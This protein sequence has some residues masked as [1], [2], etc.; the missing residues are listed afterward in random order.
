MQSQKNNMDDLFESLLQEAAVR[1]FDEYNQ[2]LTAPD[3]E[4]EFS[5]E[6]TKKMKK[7]FR[8]HKRQENMKKL[9][10]VAA[11]AACV[12]VAVTVASSVAVFS[13]DAWRVRVMNFVFDPKKIAT[14][15]NFNDNGGTT[16][17]DEY[18]RLG[19]VPMGFELTD[20]IE[21]SKCNVLYFERGEEYFFFDMQ[22]IKV[23]MTIDTENAVLENVTVKGHEG[24]YSAKENANILLWHDDYNVYTVS[25]SISKEEAMKIAESANIFVFFGEN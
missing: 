3:A 9:R 11:R 6:H 23:D 19:Y 16:Y 17:S 22:T 13:V 8:G 5:E 12:L 21:T 25:G 7:L 1:E 15:I 20:R 4:I 24:I 18:V 2:S 10:T 14:E